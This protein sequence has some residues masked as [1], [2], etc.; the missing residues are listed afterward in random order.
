MTINLNILG[1]YDVLDSIL[2]QEKYSS[3]Q[4]KVPLSMDL[5]LQ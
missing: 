5:W 3:K 1:A 4:D 2:I